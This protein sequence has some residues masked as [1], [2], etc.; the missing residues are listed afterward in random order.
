VKP[1][2]IL[3]AV[4]A[5]A[6]AL[7]GPAAAEGRP[8]LPPYT[9][10][11]R[12]AGLAEAAHEK[13][14]REEQHRLFDAAMFWGLAASDRARADGLTAAVFSA[15]QQ[16]AKTKGAEDLAKTDGKAVE[17]LKV[18]LETVPHVIG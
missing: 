7:A 5:T 13:A 12:C 8:P 18:C 1:A 17:E 14:S 4:L 9:V 6:P 11:I 3:L 10:S 16:A 15:D 2:A